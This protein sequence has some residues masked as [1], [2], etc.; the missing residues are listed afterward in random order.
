MTNRQFPRRRRVS[1]TVEWGLHSYALA[2]SMTILVFIFAVW[3]GY[4]AFAGT[5][6]VV[7][8]ASLYTRA[9]RIWGQKESTNG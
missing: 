1:E 9:M 8:A 5:C 6:V 4:W 3:Q 2:I 7:I